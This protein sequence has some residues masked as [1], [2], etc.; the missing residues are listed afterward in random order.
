MQGVTPERSGWLRAEL[1]IA[2]RVLD[3]GLAQPDRPTACMFFGP[4]RDWRG[5]IMLPARFTPFEIGDDYVLGVLTDAMAVEHVQL[6]RLDRQ[7]H[8]P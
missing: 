5:V 4:D 1:G 7:G 8:T 2:V 3:H 6:L